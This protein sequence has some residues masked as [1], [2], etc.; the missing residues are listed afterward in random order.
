MIDRTKWYSSFTAIPDIQY[1][2]FVPVVLR[3]L[4]GVGTRPKIERYSYDGQQRDS[5]TWETAD[6][7]YTSASPAK[8]HS[9]ILSEPTPTE[10]LSHLCEVLALPGT[11][12]DYHFALQGAHESLWR[13]R[14]A[15]PTLYNDIE[16]IC[17]LDIS[18]VILTGHEMF[19]D[20]P[21]AVSAFSRL[22]GIYELEGRLSAA[23]TIYEQA[24]AGGYFIRNNRAD[25]LR[26]VLGARS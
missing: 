25:Q 2:A 15:E 24:A 5:V 23:L 26:A 13:H 18:L 12:S 17:L 7:S 1:E 21:F 6:G 8:Q 22:A 9:F 4:W 14:R 19:G 10:I 3:K 11:A 20:L 16:R